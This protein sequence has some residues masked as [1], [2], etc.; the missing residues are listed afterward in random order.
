MQINKKIIFKYVYFL[1]NKLY[2]LQQSNSLVKL[3]L[4]KIQILSDC[5]YVFWLYLPDIF[6]FLSRKYV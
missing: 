6:L 1:K 2:E 3:G 5:R 4:V